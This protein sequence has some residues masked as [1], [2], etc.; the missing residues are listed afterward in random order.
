MCCHR[1]IQ[2]CFLFEP[3]RG[4]CQ[5]VVVENATADTFLVDSKYVSVEGFGKVLPSHEQLVLQQS[6]D[7]S[8]CSLLEEALS[9]E[10]VADVSTGYFVSNGVLMRK[11]ISPRMSNQDDWNSVFQIVVP[12]EYHPDVLHLAQDHS[13]AGHLGVKKTYDHVLRHFFWPGPKSDVIQYCRSCHVCQVAGKPHQK[14]PVAPLH[15]IPAIREPLERILIDCVGLLPC[16][17]ARHQYILT[18]MRAATC[19]PEAIPL[20]RI[21]AP[22][23]TKALIKFFMFGLPRVVQSDQGC[24]FMSRLFSQ[25]FQQLSI[26][27]CPSSAYHPDSQDALERFR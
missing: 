13:L 17:K 10:A 18:I 11:W 21:T 27:H 23:I 25:V 20:R 1:S 6:K 4:P 12:V 3:S 14:I 15:P 9:E 8:L 5:R 7:V 2:R 24:N 19:F 16:T 22:A 26:R